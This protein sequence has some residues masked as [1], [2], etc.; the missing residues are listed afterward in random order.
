MKIIRTA[1]M[2][3]APLCA[4]AQEKEEAK[5]P[6]KV[7]SMKCF[8]DRFINRAGISKEGFRIEGGFK[9]GNVE[10]RGS[11]LDEFAFPE[12][13]KKHYLEFKFGPGSERKKIKVNLVAKRTTAG[14]NESFLELEGTTDSDGNLECEW[15]LKRNWPIGLYTA[16]FSH[17]GQSVGSGGYFVTPEKEHRESPIKAGKVTILIEKDGKTEECAGLVPGGPEARF[18]IPTT[19]AKTKGAHVNMELARIT[20]KGEKE[21]IQGSEVDIPSWPLE[22]TVLIYTL[23]L[24]ASFPEGKYQV[25]VHVDEALLVAHDFEVKK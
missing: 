3:L 20:D 25:V 21:A 4:A 12:T 6:F 22:D 17:E 1:L 18:R 13:Q 2:V 24:P 5:P 19:G 14:L 8:S 16:Y 15:S 23:S 11:E 7:V 9:V 10:G